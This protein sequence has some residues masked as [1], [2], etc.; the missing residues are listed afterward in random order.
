MVV[1][2]I[3]LEIPREAKA[4]KEKKMAAECEKENNED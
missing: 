1:Y 2:L 4:E 3:F